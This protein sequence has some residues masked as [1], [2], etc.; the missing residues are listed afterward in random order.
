MVVRAGMG[1]GLGVALALSTTL[2]YVAEAQTATDPV[3]AQT[4]WTI[5]VYD[6][7]RQCWVVSPPRPGQSIATR[8]GRPVSVRRGDIFLFVSFWPE[9]NES[10]GGMG[11]VSFMGG[12]DFAEGEPVTVTIGDESFE[13]FTEGD[14]AWAKSPEDDERIA[15]AMKAGREA[16]ITGLSQR[17][18]T[19]TRDTFSLMG[20]TAAFNDAAERCGA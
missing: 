17:T 11:E 5:F 2:G 19:T 6:D 20:F 7:P 13:M 9:G 8:D 16:I 10:A 18:G 14:T 12:Y 15:D 3:G 1:F 4:D